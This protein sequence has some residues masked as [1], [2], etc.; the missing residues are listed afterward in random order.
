MFP[1]FALPSHFV[2]MELEQ[3]NE[4][5]D[6]HNGG[7]HVH[8]HCLEEGQRAEWGQ[9]NGEGRFTKQMGFGCLWL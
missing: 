7:I 8:V 1:G 3:K 2:A 5:G 6:V 9:R 4:G